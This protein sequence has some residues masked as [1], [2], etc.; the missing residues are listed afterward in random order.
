MRAPAYK[1]A[2]FELVD[3]Q[4]IAKAAQT[5][6]PLIMSTGM[7]NHMEISEAV[8]CAK[9]NG[10]DQLALLHCVSGYPRSSEEL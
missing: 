6:K 1:I 8:T 5:G 3:H 9:S 10:C 2:S 7:A 4:L